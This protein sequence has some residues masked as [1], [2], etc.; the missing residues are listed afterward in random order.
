[1]NPQTGQPYWSV[2]ATTLATCGT[3]VWDN[4]YVFASGGFPVPGTFAVHVSDH[5]QVVWS[6]PVKCY[7]QSLLTAQGYVYAISDR[8]VAYCWRA[9]DGE[10]MWKKRLGGKYSSSPL[11]IGD[12]I[13]VSNESGTTYVFRTNPATFE[14]Q[15]ENQLGDEIFA[16]PAVVGN[17]LYMRYARHDGEQRQEYLI[18]IGEQ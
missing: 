18:C 8:G 9:S 1:L 13:H 17:A 5:P 7:E 12:Q 11:L 14:L 10:Q 3:V 16:T 6:K 2:P 15:A 4:D